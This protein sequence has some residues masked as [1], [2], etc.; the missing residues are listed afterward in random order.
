MVVLEFF[1]QLDPANQNHDTFD[2]YKKDELMLSRLAVESFLM[3]N[4]FEK[5]LVRYRHQPDFKSLSGA[6]LLIMALKTCNASAS[7]DVDEAT[8]SLAALSLDSFPV[9]NIAEMMTYQS[10]ENSLHDPK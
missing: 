8:A 2:S 3:T 10:N 5:I 9:D 1:L 7:L 4:F 6:C